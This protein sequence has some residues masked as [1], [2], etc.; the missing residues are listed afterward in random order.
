MYQHL[1]FLAFGTA[2]EQPKTQPSLPIIASTHLSSTRQNRVI[3]SLKLKYYYN[4]DFY[5]AGLELVE[6][7]DSPPDI[8][9]I[10]CGGGGLCAGVATAV[11]LSGWNDTRV[12]GVEPQNGK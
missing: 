10:C 1:K 8:L 4:S 7:C 9:L 3:I 12:Y 11:K 5:S 2:R 6:Q